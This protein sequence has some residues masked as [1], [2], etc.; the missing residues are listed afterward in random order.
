MNFQL[1]TELFQSGQ[2]IVVILTYIN[3]KYVSGNYLFITVVASCFTCE[4]L[5]I[6]AANN[7]ALYT[8]IIR[9]SG[10]RVKT[11]LEKSSNEWSLFSLSYI[12]YL[13]KLRRIIKE[14]KQIW[15]HIFSSF[16]VFPFTG[17]HKQLGAEGCI[18]L[19]SQLS[20]LHICLSIR[21]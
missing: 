10:F 4:D 17:L 16:F 12:S 7:L 6:N 21:W 13:H 8:F 18:Y 1:L 14:C 11:Q 2:K 15:M 5:F 19:F 9:D 3:I 20:I